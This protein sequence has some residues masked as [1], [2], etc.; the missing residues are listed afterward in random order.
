MRDLRA[1][2]KPF[3]TKVLTNMIHMVYNAI[4][5]KDQRTNLRFRGGR[6]AEYRNFIGTHLLTA[7]RKGSTLRGNQFTQVIQKG[8]QD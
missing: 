8:K 2:I 5:P 6:F 3:K 1:I 4:E 7:P